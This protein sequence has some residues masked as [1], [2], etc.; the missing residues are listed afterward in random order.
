[1]NLVTHLG[2]NLGYAGYFRREIS[3]D[4]GEEELYSPSS[5]I[6]CLLF[7][8]ILEIF[9]TGFCPRYIN[10]VNIS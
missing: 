1:M 2:G 3:K 5:Q 8:F 9:V 4:N 6:M 7:S 10:I